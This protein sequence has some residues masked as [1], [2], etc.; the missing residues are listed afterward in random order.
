MMSFADFDM[1]LSY[2]GIMPEHLAVRN[3][4]GV[5]DVTHMGR[6]L[7][8]GLNAEKFLNYVTTN[9]VTSLTPLSAQYSTMCNERGGIKDDFVVSRLEPEKFLM[10]YNAANRE[11]DY[12]W[13]ISNA[14]E[15]G[16]GTENVSD[17]TALFAVQ[18]P[19][20]EKTLQKLSSENLSIIERFKCDWIK[21]ANVKTFVSRT[22]Y[23]GEDGFE[24][25]VWDSP[26]QKPENAV[27][28]WNAILEAGREFGIEP[29][30]LGARDTLRLEAGLCLYGNDID[31]STT[32]F[33]AAIGF[34]VKLEK[35]DFIGK[36][37]LVN[38][39]AEGIKRK[40][41]GIS[42]LGAGIPRQ[43]FEVFKNQL[44]IGSVTSGTFSPLLDRGVAMACVSSEN[45]SVGERLKVKIRE[46]LVEGEMVKFP[47]YDSTM[48]GYG[49]KT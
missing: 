39:K 16:V 1:P 14:K 48:Y 3:N 45:V 17:R 41:V 31:E 20:A 7:I 9:N 37:A 22:G 8:S 46:R 27:K 11:K 35:V 21:L 44:K 13:L 42:M 36:E 25:F 19:K 29:C 5:F 34:V 18:G 32:P 43:H 33:E 6:C 40:R 12:L 10:V 23:T 28:V 49:R 26:L 47:F 15:F 30:G 38:Q 4:V 2:K 24:V